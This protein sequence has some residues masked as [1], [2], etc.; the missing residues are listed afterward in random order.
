MLI[1]FSEIFH[2]FKVHITGILH[3]GA[4][5]LEERTD[6]L[7][8]LKEDNIYWV[9]ANPI[10]CDR[11]K[12]L[13]KNAKIYNTAISDTNNEFIDLIVTNNGQSSSVLEL[14]NHLNYYPYIKEIGR[15]SVKNTT[16]SEFVTKIPRDV[17][18]LNMDI[19]GAELLA[20]K[21]GLDVLN[22]FDYIYLEVNTEELYKGCGM[23]NEIK[24]LLGQVRDGF[25]FELKD[26][27][28]LKENWGDALFVK[29][30]VTTT[31]HQHFALMIPDF[32]VEEC[33]KKWINIL[34]NLNFSNAPIFDIGAKNSD[35][36]VAKNIVHYFEPNKEYFNK[37]L[38]NS[39]TNNA[40]TQSYFNKIGLGN[41]TCQSIYYSHCESLINRKHTLHGCEIKDKENIHNT[42]N[43]IKL[44]DYCHDKKIKECF[45]IKID[46]EGY[47]LEVLKGGGNIFRNCSF[48]QFEYGGTYRDAGITLDDVI[49]KLFSYGF[50][51]I[52]LIGNE[53]MILNKD[54]YLLIQQ[55]EMYCNLLA[56][57]IEM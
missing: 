25:Y 30:S 44:D 27:K 9:E 24:E 50:R 12:S 19:Q 18:F 34:L 17:N 5:L 46:V 43:I 13:F 37:L 11:A 7:Q 4:H 38:N 45:L 20:L 42:I 39:A 36:L 10:I 57:R 28:M 21:G 53:L 8:F 41:E 23:L 55:K 15:M 54:L 40:N 1:P 49:Q 6:Y 29:R 51:F 26:I 31:L 52:Y 16:L 32:S 47:E 2:K 48:V 14:K 3:I 33:E 35:F 56:S 22:R